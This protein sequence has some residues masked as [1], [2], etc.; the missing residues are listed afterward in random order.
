MGREDRADTHLE[1]PVEIHEAIKDEDD[2]M[3]QVVTD[4]IQIYLGVEAD[5]LAA[6][7]RRVEKL[8]ERIQE[9]DE[10]IRSLES[11]RDELVDRRRRLETRIEAIHDERRE[12]D[13]IID[14]VIDKLVANP[15]LGI[16]SQQSELEAAAEI[17]N[18]GIP[19]EEAIQQVC[20]DVRARVAEREVSIDPLRLRRDMTVAN[21]ENRADQLDPVLRSLQEETDGSE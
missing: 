4:A 1:L 13:T 10:E 9:C 6:L 11:E 5:S 16:A 2:P 17:Q 14:D 3:W 8:D 15:S 20:S 7:N 21:G 19:S 18:N 12:Y